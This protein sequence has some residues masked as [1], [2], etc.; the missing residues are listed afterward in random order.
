MQDIVEMITG[1]NLQGPA[2]PFAFAVSGADLMV[3][4][5]LPTAGNGFAG[6]LVVQASTGG[7]PGHAKVRLVDGTVEQVVVWDDEM[8]DVIRHF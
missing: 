1:P 5:V 4:D 7:H 2:F 3:G 8:V 6:S